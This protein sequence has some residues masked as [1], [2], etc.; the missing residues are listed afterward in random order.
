LKG[1]AKI[2][3]D[4]Q[5]KLR[6]FFE[7]PFIKIVNADRDICESARNYVWTY[8]M[9]SKDAVHMATAEVASRVV[10][11]HGLF[12]WDSDFLGLNGKTHLKFP[13]TVPFLEQGILQ[14]QNLEAGDAD[15]GEEVSAEP[16]DAPSK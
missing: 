7:F 13:I 15:P 1:H 6:M 11:I 14:L 4:A 8:K 9:A 5:Q 3:D 10:E 16:D 12:S 2:A